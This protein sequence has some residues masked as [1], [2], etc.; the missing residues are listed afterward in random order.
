MK[1]DL[2]YEADCPNWRVAANALESLLDEFDVTLE[3]HES[4]S[5]DAA[6]TASYRG[7]PTTLLDGRDPFESEDGPVDAACRIY[8]T[9][10]GP[11]GVPTLDQLRFA[12][13]AAG[14]S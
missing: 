9:P 4:S 12:L 2:L 5:L 3:L 14:R 7:S 6:L 8:P 11:A 10:T 13:R 1:V